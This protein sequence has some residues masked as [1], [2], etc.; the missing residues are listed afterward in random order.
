MKME[1][2]V[3][4][5]EGEKVILISSDK[6]NLVFPKDKLPAEIK[7]G[8]I[9]YLT[10]SPNPEAVEKTKESAKQLLNEILKTD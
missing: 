9:L 2:T 6:T 1:L 8:D 4:R 10:I 5:M 7:E 3:D